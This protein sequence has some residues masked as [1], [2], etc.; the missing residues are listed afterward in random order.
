MTQMLIYEK[1]VVLDIK[2]HKN[3]RV[4]PVTD[5]SFAASANSIPIAGV[6]FI[7]ASKDYPIAFIKNSQSAYI[8]TIILGLQDNQNLFVSKEGKWNA[9]YIPAYIRR[10]PFVPSTTNEAGKLN[11]CIDEAYKGIDA[12]KGTPVFNEDGTPAPMLEKAVQL[13]QDYHMQMQHTNSFT[14]RL[15]DSGVLQEMKAEFG[16]R[17]GSK[18]FRLSGIFVVNEEKLRALDD[19]KVLDFFRKG[20]FAWIY[21][22]LTSLSNFAR[23]LDK[24]FAQPK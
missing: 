18:K 2:K 20:E 13:I 22:H 23:M 4:A 3:T 10:Y 8:P 24:F 19:A 7:E 6:E 5:F 21:S 11:I 9:F 1:I 17:D 14:S 15:A 12:E 16:T